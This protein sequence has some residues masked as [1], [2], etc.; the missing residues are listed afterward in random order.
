MEVKRAGDADRPLGQA[1]LHFRASHAASSADFPER[2][3]GAS[4]AAFRA[5]ARVPCLPDRAQSE[6]PLAVTASA[7]VLLVEDDDGMRAA[8]ERLLRAAGFACDAYP[9]AE[10]L[11][12][13]SGA[14]GAA[15]LVSDVRLPAMSGLKLLEVLRE[16]GGWPPTILITAHDAPGLGA[17]AMRR[18]AA[19]YLVKPF[20][21]RELLGAIGDAIGSAGPV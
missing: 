20:Q 3:S 16:Q 17:E 13:R 5:V 2:R 18:G 15:C 1:A 14:N 4:S 7:T 11:L 12:M 8:I 21:G 19:A 6:P 10:A 9:S